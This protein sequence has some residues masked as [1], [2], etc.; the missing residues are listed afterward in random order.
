MIY[1]H[2]NEKL[3]G[4]LRLTVS[5]PQID[6]QPADTEDLIHI[7]WNHSSDAVRLFIDGAELSL[8]PERIITTTY[9]HQVQVLSGA[10]NLVLFS[11]NKPYYC[12]Y[13]HDAEIS[14]N[15]II[16]FG[17]QELA[18]IQLSKEEQRKMEML[19]QVFIDE[20]SFHDNVQGEMLLMMLKRLIIICTRLVKNQTG[21]DRS[22]V[23]ENDLLR[24]FRFLVD[25]HFR[26]KKRVQDY[27]ALLHRSPKTLSNA[28]SKLGGKTPLTIIQGRI[29]LEARR[30]LTYTDKHVNEIAFEL[31]YEEPGGFFKTFKKHVG[32]SPAKFREAQENAPSGILD[33]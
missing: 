30:L 22:N 31:G 9:Y 17:A 32:Q 7:I 11:F 14:C 33:S 16:F 24:Q 1:S 29:V 25:M 2:S 19:V 5:E 3:G 6:W 13:D 20:F 4:L 23:Q 26:E 21:L 18:V 27:A 8:Q 28:I 15:G 12:I 10:E